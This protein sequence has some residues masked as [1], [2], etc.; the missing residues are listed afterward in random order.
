MKIIKVA[1]LLL[2]FSNTSAYAKN[3][4]ETA[5]DYFD[6]LKKK[7]YSAAATYFDPQAL[8]EFREMMS[9]INEMP[10]EGRQGFIEAFFGQGATKE[11]V[12]KLS[13]SDFFSSF[14]KA[15]MKQA[16]KAGGINFDNME[17]LGEVM[18]GSQIAHV[19]SRNKISMGGMEL[20]TM[21]VVS[22][23]K[24]GKEWKALLS[25]KIKGMASQLR[26]A[27]NRQR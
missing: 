3:A 27:I 14:L 21:E 22:F 26:A 23:K 10:A 17:V 25:G 24:N 2:I 6:M 9:F 15:I 1:L 4:T 11:S 18:E 13:N 8:K 7:N 5:V 16:E 12:S 19:V 20:E